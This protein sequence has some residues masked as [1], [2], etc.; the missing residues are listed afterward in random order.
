MVKDLIDPAIRLDHRDVVAGDPAGSYPGFDRFDRQA[1]LRWDRYDTNAAG[2]PPLNDPVFDLRYGYDA[3]SN[4]THTERKVYDAQSQTYAH[5]GLHRLTGYEAGV[6]DD[7]AA[8]QPTVNLLSRYLDKAWE[9]DAV[10]NPLAIRRNETDDFY[11]DG[12]FSAA[13][14]IVERKVSATA[15][16]SRLGDE[17][18]NAADTTS[19]WETVSGA[20]SVA[21]GQLTVTQAA[22]NALLLLGGEVGPHSGDTRVTLPATLNAPVR[23]G[24]VF[25]YQDAQNY[26]IIGFYRDPAASTG[27]RQICQVSGGVLTVVASSNAGVNAGGTYSIH[28]G[29]VQDSVAIFGMSHTIDAGFPGGRIGFYADTVGVK[30]DWA[31]F[32]PNDHGRPLASRWSTYAPDSNPSDGL[33]QVNTDA[34]RHRPSLLIG[35]RVGA[36]G[37]PFR[38]TLSMT[39]STASRNYDIF[40]FLFGAE[41][42][43]IYS[44]IALRHKSG[45]PA[46]PAGSTR[47]KDVTITGTGTPANVPTPA[48]ASDRLWY[49]IASDGTTVTVKAL[50]DNAGAPTES[51]WSGAGV[52][53]TSSDFPLTGGQVGFRAAYGVALMRHFTLE[54]DHDNDGTWTT[55]FDQAYNHPGGYATV[56]YDHDAA[57]NLTFDG[58]FAYTY[59]ASNR[60][61]EVHNAYRDSGGAVQ[62]GSVVTIQAYDGLGRRITRAVRNSGD[63]DLTY[64]YHYDG[65]RMVEARNGSD[66]VLKQQV[67][68]LDYIDELVRVDINQDPFDSNENVA[69]RPFYALHDAQYNLLGLVSHSG[70]LVERYEYTP[71]GQRQVYG[72]GWLLADVDGDGMVDNVDLQLIDDARGTSDPAHI[73]DISGDGDVDVSDFDFETNSE[74]GDYLL[75]NAAVGTSTSPNDPKL[76]TPRLGSYRDRNGIAL[77]ETGHQGLHH[78]EATGLQI[79]RPR[80]YSPQLGRFLNRTHWGYIQNRMS[81]YDYEKANPTKYFEPFSAVEV[82]VGG[83][84]AYTVGGGGGAIAG[85]IGGGGS[86]AAGG[87]IGGGGSIAAGGVAGTAAGAGAVGIAVGVGAGVGVAALAGGGGYLIGDA[88]LPDGLDGNPELQLG[89]SASV[90]Q[91]INERRRREQE[92]N[93]ALLEALDFYIGDNLRDPDSGGCINPCKLQIRREITSGGAGSAE[94]N[95]YENCELINAETLLIGPVKV[96]FG[97]YSCP[98]SGW[99]YRIPCGLPLNDIDNNLTDEVPSPFNEFISRVGG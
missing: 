37:Q 33:W 97:T 99:T 14:E 57:G 27:K 3:G 60:L 17:F 95:G 2:E 56:E 85:S 89:P 9:L 54:T 28:T 45:T 93:R 23:V 69:E 84:T 79:Q 26:W 80:P 88:L 73:A 8:A 58:V 92:Q 48:N 31:R 91:L 75:A 22:P 11:K 61:V 24:A 65:Q 90:Q 96:C 70:K 16:N 55:E 51:A 29:S 64:A 4:R 62:L 98:K 5:D 7:P 82:V 15:D 34:R 12:V 18:S 83:G 42:E 59:D 63:H 46:A 35:P 25:G 94:C 68:G 13:N 66:Q 49:R 30:V 32:W 71:Y 53:Y 10:G 38:A 52:A 21:S 86:I 6:I 41:D 44:E 72:S 74:N 81:L 40:W 47:G 78:D 67:W 20:Y 1:R 50:V 36:A 87:S 76:L 43:A 39:R 19:S 77:N